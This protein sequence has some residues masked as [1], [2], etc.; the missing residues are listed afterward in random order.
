MLEFRPMNGQSQRDLDDLFALYQ[1]TPGYFRAVYGREPNFGDVVEALTVAP[2]DCGDAVKVFGG[3][4]SGDNLIGCSDMV[5][6]YPTQRVAYLGL[7]L[8]RKDSQAQGYGTWAHRMLCEIALSKGCQSMRLAVV[9]TNSPAV[10]F[11]NREGYREIGR[12]NSQAYLGD[13]I[14]LERRL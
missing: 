6:G 7:L 3:Y 11:W 8:F 4:W 12:R 1:S 9:E 14:I 2:P 5:F 10:R 13:I